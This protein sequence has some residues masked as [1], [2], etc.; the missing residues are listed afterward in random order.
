MSAVQ[1]VLVT[2]NLPTVLL[3]VDLLLGGVTGLPHC[4]PT[5]LQD[6]VSWEIE[7]HS[8]LS[9]HYPKLYAE[10]TRAVYWMTDAPQD[11]GISISIKNFYR[12]IEAL[13]VFIRVPL[14]TIQ[15]T[16]NKK[17]Y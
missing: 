2:G 5:V 13:F 10:S 15:M 3:L 14:I 12:S 4:H 1:T 11:V 17:D 16:L 8:P 7:Y 6:Q 9:S